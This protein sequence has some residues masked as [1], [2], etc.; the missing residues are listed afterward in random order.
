MK[1]HF[2]SCRLIRRKIII[3]EPEYVNQRR[4]ELGMDPIE[5]YQKE[6]GLVWTVEQK[7]K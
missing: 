1:R 7:E 3:M 6:Y 5:D 4:R 2:Q